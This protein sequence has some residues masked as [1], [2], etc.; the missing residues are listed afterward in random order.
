MR[1]PIDYIV[2]GFEGNEFDGSI[3]KAVGDAVASGAIGLVAMSGVTKNAEG[4]VE[5]FSITDTDLVA[6]DVV[7]EADIQEVADL[8]ENNTTAGLL[9][10]EQLWAKPL[11][12]AL[13]AANGVLVAEGR[14]HPEA[15]LELD[16]E[17]E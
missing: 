12:A 7:D 10:V 13:I 1:G 17:N 5:A 2:V 11:K 4:E 6:S 14:I 3:L 9:V 15:A 16:K 8:L